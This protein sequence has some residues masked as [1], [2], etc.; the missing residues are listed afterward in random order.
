MKASM[1]MFLARPSIFSANP[2]PHCNN[3]VMKPAVMH[4]NTVLLMLNLQT[5]LDHFYFLQC[6]RSGIRCFFDSGIRIHDPGWGKY[7]DP[8][9][10][11]GMNIPD[12]FSGCS[13][14]IFW[15]KILKFFDADP[16][17]AA[18]RSWIRNEHPVSNT[19]FF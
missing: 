19:A 8:D 9:A 11:S 15:I 4:Y 16:D 3:F 6:C 7:L 17:P 1:P 18:P 14:T 5:T 2:I 13:E 10:G 12:H